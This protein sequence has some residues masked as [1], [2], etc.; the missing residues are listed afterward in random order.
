MD[1]D[2]IISNLQALDVKFENLDR[3][4]ITP[5]LWNSIFQNN[6]YKINKHMLE[7]YFIQEDSSETF[8]SR[9]YTY[10]SKDAQVKKYIDENI[11]DYFKLLLEDVFKDNDR[12]LINDEI[13]VIESILNNGKIKLTFRQQYIAKLHTVIDNIKTISE[14]KLWHDLLKHKKVVADVNTI[15]EY[16]YYANTQSFADDR[17]N[18]CTILIDFMCSIDN[19]DQLDFGTIKWENYPDCKEDFYGL[20]LSTERFKKDISNII[21]SAHDIEYELSEFQRKIE[22]KYINIMIENNLLAQTQFNCKM[23]ISDYLSECVC[24]YINKNVSYVC[25]LISREAIDLKD[26]FWDIVLYRDNKVSDKDKMLMVKSYKNNIPFRTIYPN[27]ILFEI[28]DH[29]L[30]S[31]GVIEM[32][33]WYTDCGSVEIQNRIL[34]VCRSRTDM[35]QVKTQI[36]RQCKEVYE[37]LEREGVFSEPSDF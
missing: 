14:K 21:S 17:T 3:N 10:I 15:S 19:I 5:T 24:N 34:D 31:H 27:D 28:M 4:K 8:W 18:M 29:H 9:S 12:D 36:S 23:I 22:P 26:E 11:N 6:L 7:A 37:I 20:I 30:S 2:K 35:Y 16:F 25:N 1:N 13:P 33:K 32:C